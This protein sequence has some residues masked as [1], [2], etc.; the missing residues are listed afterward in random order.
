MQPRQ[1]APALLVLTLLAA[2]GGA[3]APA[4]APAS[5]SKAA[6]PT[7]TAA[8]AATKITVAY[9][10]TAGTYTPLYVAKDDGFFARNGLD[11]TLYNATGKDIAP[12]IAGDAQI[13]DADGN[14]GATAIAKGA[15][16]VYFASDLK[17]YGFQCWASP[18]ITNVSQLKGKTLALSEPGQAVASAGLSMLAKFGLNP[19][20]VHLV[21]ISSVPGRVAALLV[22]KVDAIVVSAPQGLRAQQ[23]GFKML[24]DLAKLP[25]MSSGYMATRPYLKSHPAVIT[26]FLKSL[27]QSIAFIKDPANKQ[28]VEAAMGHYTLITQPSLLDNAYAYYVP[29]WSTDLSI[30]DSVLDVSIR[31]VQSHDHIKVTPSQLVDLSLV[32]RLQS[33]AS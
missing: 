5:G 33:Q 30:P 29:Q 26:A 23:Q 17:D 15:N 22:H 28:R 19:S 2:C 18:S 20:D 25:Y 4:A 16:V 3:G 12:L 13:A 8:P 21:Y 14:Y 6:T 11:V 1:F 31:W 27:R 9:G 7:A 10:N 32:D 24:Y